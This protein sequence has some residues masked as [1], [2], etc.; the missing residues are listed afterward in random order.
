MGEPQE[1]QLSVTA[2][3]ANEANPH[4][5]TNGAINQSRIP[6]PRRKLISWIR[7]GIYAIFLLA[8]QSVGM[9]LGRLYFDKGGNSKWMGTLVQLVG[10]PILLPYYL[11]SPKKNKNAIT[12]SSTNIISLKPPSTLLLASIYTVLGILIAADCY[13]YSVGLMY[14]PVS[15]YSLI[16]ASQLAFNAFFSF[17]LNSQKFTFYIINSLVLL[18]LSSTLLVFQSG[19]DDTHN[20]SKGKYVIGFICTVGASAGYGL[21]L[22]LTQFFL[23]RV[24]KRESFSVVMD[25]LVYQSL[26]ASLAILVGLFASGDWK[27]LDEEMNSFELG[28]L[29]YVMTL[30]WTAIIWQLFGIGAIGLILE[31]SSLFSN[32]MSVLGLPIVPVLAVFFF[33]EKMDGIKV[34]ALLLAIWGFISYIYQSYLD[35]YSSKKESS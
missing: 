22:S 26:V 14:L 33:H 24:L 35:D 8:G 17:F 15:T 32:V 34:M 20:N 27:G 1:V 2:Q 12:E 13:L 10:F 25:I 16:C 5:H 11:F 6:Q 23:N 18:T 30:V 9:L 21:V 19:S 7:I 31:V 28:K 29:S 3:E 4:G